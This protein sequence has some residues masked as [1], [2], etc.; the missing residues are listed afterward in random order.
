MIFWWGKEVI[1]GGVGE[2]DA[3]DVVDASGRGGT[4]VDREELR[5]SEPEGLIP[6]HGGY[7]K[8]KS[9]QV[10]E[11]V[12]DV[13]VRFCDRYID[14]KSRTHDQMV[15]AARSG[16]RNIVEGSQAS[17]TSKKTELKLTGVA[18][19]SLEELRRD[20]LAFLRQRRLRTW[21]Q[22]DSRR[23]ALIARR[24][25]TAEDFAAWT[26]D[27][28]DGRCGRRGPGGHGDCAST[29]S[30]KSTS[31]TYAEISAN[32]ALT[33]VAVAAG[34]LDR[35]LA[36]LAKAFENEGGFTERLYRVR[37]QKRKGDRASS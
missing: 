2:L 16:S 5:M 6:K 33:L 22:D 20:Y 3:M 10:A 27:V 34:L 11:L 24:C 13:T 8:L 30:M 26:R 19:A 29:S 18:R 21:D 15:Q 9:Y 37:S 28:H 32:G 25:A 14:K 17:G 4:G 31:S 36:S 23:S 12:F 35:Q 1:G 7:R